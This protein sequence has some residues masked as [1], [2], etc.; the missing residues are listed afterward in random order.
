MRLGLAFM[1]ED[2]LQ[3]NTAA[4]RAW[5]ENG[6]VLKDGGD[7]LVGLKCWKTLVLNGQVA[8]PHV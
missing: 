4:V 7:V 8:V 6:G 3:P 1:I 5:F 2:G